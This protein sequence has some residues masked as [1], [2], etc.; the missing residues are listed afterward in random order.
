MT[1]PLNTISYHEPGARD[2]GL[3]GAEQVVWLWSSIRGPCGLDHHTRCHAG[4]RDEHPRD[5]NAYSLGFRLS[6]SL[7]AG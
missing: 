1:D 4:Q 2:A 7:Q 3:R 5:Y 6:L